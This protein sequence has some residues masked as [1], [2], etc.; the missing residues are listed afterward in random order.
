MITD[1][2]DQAFKDLEQQ[3]QIPDPEPN[4]NDDGF[5]ECI[6]MC[7]FKTVACCDHA[8]SKYPECIGEDHEECPLYRKRTSI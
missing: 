2:N 5:R 8:Q 6:H 7:F 3:R 4:K 1:P